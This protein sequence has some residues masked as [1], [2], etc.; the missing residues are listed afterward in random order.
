MR[1]FYIVI[2]LTLI[3]CFCSC[4]SHQKPLNGNV[5]MEN[6]RLS[7]CNDGL[8]SAEVEDE[9]HEYIY[10]SAINDK[11]LKIEQKFFMNCCTEDV[12]IFIDTDEHIVTINIADDDAGC[13]CIC[14]GMANYEIVNLQEDKTYKFIFL[15]NGQEYHTCEIHFTIHTNSEIL[16]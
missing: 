11:T 8:R 4:D 6:L 16:L 10:Y 5:Y 9:D 12:D 1:F 14:P 7:L 13:N 3:A 15:R 2:I